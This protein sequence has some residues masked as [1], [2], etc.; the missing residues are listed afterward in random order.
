MSFDSDYNKIVGIVAHKLRENSIHILEPEDIINDAYLLMSDSKKPYSLNIF[1]DACN[2]IIFRSRYTFEKTNDKGVSAG[3]H[4]YI[5]NET[6]MCK[7]CKEVFPMEMFYSSRKKDKDM[8][9]KG[10]YCKK[11]GSGTV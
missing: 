7:D 6:K 8:V 2:K 9:F 4:R 5:G 3:R 1:L 11:C 10:S